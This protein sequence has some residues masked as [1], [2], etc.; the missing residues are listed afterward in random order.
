MGTRHYQGAPAKFGA[1]PHRDACIE[2]VDVEMRDRHG[3]L[4]S[5]RIQTKDRRHIAF[6]VGI[7]A[8]RLENRD[9]PSQLGEA[10]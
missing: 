1:I 4:G 6:V 3:A 7:F 2:R 8:R 5:L 9:F 10:E